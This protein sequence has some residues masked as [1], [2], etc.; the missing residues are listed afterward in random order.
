L[1]SD[2]EIAG[3][4]TAGHELVDLLADYLEE[5]PHGPVFRPM[6][7]AERAGLANMRLPDESLE[8]DELLRVCRDE[9]A[10]HPMGNGHPRF[11]AWV[12]SAPAPAGILG[13]LAAATI[14][15]SCAGG[16]HAATYLERATTRW[17]AELVGYP[18]HGGYGVLTSGASM[19]SIICL[20]AARQ[21]AVRRAGLDVREHGMAAAQTAPLVLYSSVETHSC[22]RKAVELLGL[23]STRHHSVPVDGDGRIDIAALREA[24]AGDHARELT[25]FCLVGNAGTVGC[26]AVDPLR[27]L[28]DVAEEEGL[29]LHVDGA[30][31]AFGVLDP[32]IAEYFDG[33]SR[34]DSLA[35]DPHKWLG[36]P[37]DCGC[38]LVRDADN[39]RD[40]FSLVPPYLRTEEGRGFGG[41]TWFSEYTIEQTRPYRALPLWMTL[42]RLGRAGLVANIVRCRQ[43]ARRLGEMVDTD[44]SLTL[45]GPVSTSIV[46]FYYRPPGEFD[47]TLDLDEITRAVVAAV[48]ERGRTFLSGT[49]IG[50][51][52]ALRACI[53]NPA[54]TEQD[55]RVL[56]AE[57]REV[58]TRLVSDRRS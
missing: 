18:L 54:A 49:I 40:T 3:L 46:A 52:E 36:V 33:M 29:W 55:L 22:I 7:R 47:A 13:A 34:A 53:L 30:Y 1:A 24:I 45:A 5:L 31:G 44:P 20:A 56:L 27:A 9:L 57:I 8:W 50:G 28:G 48:Q 39:L 42:A 21:W 25:P 23:G 58:A 43:L 17:L 11:F 15:P 4:R 41:P 6:T 2:S 14:N 51:R 10:A 16:D 37:V 38:A 35:L 26:G 19:A 12:N 32:S